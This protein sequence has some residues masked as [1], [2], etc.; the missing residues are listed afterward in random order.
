MSLL[1]FFESIRNPV[2][3]IIGA[4]VT[5]FGSEIFLL[6]IIGVVFWC[7]DKELGYKVAF[8]Y[9]V[10]R[11]VNNVLKV[12]FRVPRP[13]VKDPDFTVVESVKEGATGYSFPSGHSNSIGVFGTTFFMNTHHRWIKI[14]AIALMVLVP[15][16]RMYLGV[17]TLLDVTVGLG[18]AIIL[19]FIVN[20]VISGTSF[21]PKHL[22]PIM[23]AMLLFPLVLLIVAL[24]MYYNGLIEY[25]NMSDS[26]KSSGAFAGMIIGWYIERTRVNFSVKCNKFWKQIV[27]LVVGF[28]VVL[29]LKSGL[30]E[31][32]LLI[33]S[34]FWPGDFIRYFIITFFAIGIYPML[35]KKFLSSK[36]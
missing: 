31:L 33:G 2:L 28:G 12:A 24:A 29:G 6:V 19:T 4:G 5:F 17:H 3:D 36:Y 9:I 20:K 15:V 22:S 30:K 26:I 13:W 23:L 16:S 34:E 32:F 14:V 35:I 27:K 11:A 7:V 1:Y 10:A 21:D 18:L 8:S 25:E